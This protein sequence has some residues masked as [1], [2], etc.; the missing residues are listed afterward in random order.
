VLK[1]CTAV[2]NS[3]TDRKTTETPLPVW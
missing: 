1:I 3:G 2:N